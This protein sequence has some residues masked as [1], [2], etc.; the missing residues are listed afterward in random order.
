MAGRSPLLRTLEGEEHVWVDAEQGAEVFARRAEEALATG[1]S[2]VAMDAEWQDPCPLSVLQL[3]L[4]VDPTKPPTVFL[5]DL[6]SSVSELGRVWARR[7]L[8]EAQVL[9]FSPKEDVRR[10]RA[11]GLVEGEPSWV[12]L[13]LYNWGL[14]RMPGLQAVVARALG[15]RMDKSLQ[16]SDWNR[17]P[18]SAE[19]LE[20]AALDASVLLRLHRCNIAALPRLDVASASETSASASAASCFRDDLGMAQEKERW[21]HFRSLEH[22][23][24]PRLLSGDNALSARDRNGDLGF[25]LP[26]SLNRLMRKL[27]GLGL[28]TEMLAEGAPARRLVECAEESDRIILYYSTKNLLPSKAAHRT[29]MLRSTSP[30]EQVRE[31]I[32]AFEVDLDSDCLCGRCVQCNAWDWQLVGRQELRDHPKVAAKTLEAF[33]EF[34]LCGG[35]GKVYW[36]GKMFVKALDHFRTF[37]PKEGREGGEEM[38][39]RSQELESLGWSSSRVRA[40]MVREGWISAEQA[41]DDASSTS[42]HFGGERPA[43]SGLIQP[44][45]GGLRAI[46]WPEGGVGALDEFGA[47]AWGGFVM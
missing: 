7:L 1:A 31:I 4:S 28:D 30:D 41:L 9:A 20:Y 5:I 46:L 43:S 23:Q 22:R 10:L 2:L 25:I 27:R 3:A 35:C 14:G 16:I 18:L 24:R 15:L 37:M 44:E 39:A 26:A 34:W 38:A 8:A 36:E 13:Q 29:Y 40:A 45:Q 47:V 42:G 6:A 11:A 17:R 33:D 21:N 32:E 12:D 19:Q